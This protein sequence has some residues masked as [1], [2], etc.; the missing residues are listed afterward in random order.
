LLIFAKKTVHDNFDMVQMDEQA[1][2]VI[3]QKLAGYEKMTRFFGLT[4]EQAAHPSAPDWMIDCVKQYQ[5]AFTI[6][7]SMKMTPV[8]NYHKET[9][10]P[11]LG[12]TQQGV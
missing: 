6:A 12:K 11:L 8:E 10:N 1:L 5:T 7:K 2:A 9:T 4:E 3:F